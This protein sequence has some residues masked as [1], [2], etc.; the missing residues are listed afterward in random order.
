MRLDD[1]WAPHMMRSDVR[2]DG[3]TLGCPNTRWRLY[4][5]LAYKSVQTG[6]KRRLGGVHG[7]K[8]IRVYQPFRPLSFG[9]TPLGL[10]TARLTNGTP[11][12]PANTWKSI[13]PRGWIK[14]GGPVDTFNEVREPTERVES[15]DPCDDWLLICRVASGKDPFRLDIDL[16]PTGEIV[17]PVTL[18]K[19]DARAR[20]TIGRKNIFMLGKKAVE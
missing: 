14:E 10:L 20:T 2:R 12:S 9:S 11:I 17:Q 1:K 16:V 19:P 18:L 15:T 8:L 5:M 13:N 7:G 6:P 4:P 3:V